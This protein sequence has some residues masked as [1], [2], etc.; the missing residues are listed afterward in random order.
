[1]HQRHINLVTHDLS[2]ITLRWRMTLIWLSVRSSQSF[3]RALEGL[4]E[5]TVRPPLCFLDSHSSII[6]PT[7][8]AKTRLS[9]FFCVL[10]W[11]NK[12]RF[13]PWKTRQGRTCQEIRRR[14]KSSR[15]LR[16]WI[17]GCNI[18]SS[19]FFKFNSCEAEEHSLGQPFWR[20]WSKSC[21]QRA[22]ASQHRT[23]HVVNPCNCG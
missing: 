23:H 13:C 7:T 12:W 4:R 6:S 19:I 17:A 21:R 11:Q 20:V 14:E 10:L 15:A 22:Q 2:S 5:G 18:L 8:I 1:M 9:I 16:H 3:T